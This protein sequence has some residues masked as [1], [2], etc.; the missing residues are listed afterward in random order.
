MMI[1]SNQIVKLM[2][3]TYFYC[4]CRAFFKFMKHFYLRS[5]KYEINIQLAK[6]P[7]V[8][9]YSMQPNSNQSHYTQPAAILIYTNLFIHL[10]QLKIN[11]YFIL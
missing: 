2:R 7:I 10:L 1:A 9:T 4:L 3:S 8:D 6:K 5:N 11:V